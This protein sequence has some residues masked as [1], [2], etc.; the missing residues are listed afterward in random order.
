MP[1]RNE[2]G[3]RT[4]IFA[5][6]EYP[7]PQSVRQLRERGHQFAATGADYLV[8]LS[9]EDLSFPKSLNGRFHGLLIDAGS[10]R[11]V[12]WFNLV[13]GVVLLVAST[14]VL[15]ESADPDAHRV[16]IS[17]VV[18]GA[19]ALAAFTFAIIN[20]ETSGFAAPGVI[21]LLGLA[22]VAGAVFLWRESRAAHPVGGCQDDRGARGENGAGCR[23]RQ[24]YFGL[25][26]ATTPH[27]FLLAPV[28]VWSTEDC[29]PG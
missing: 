6:E 12:F 22:V 18:L 24:A 14:R 21:A 5:G 20:A 8:H 17:G 3:D 28:V 25:R 13:L 7:D 1:L 19:A 4:L 26:P 16:D 10:W 27:W 9:E 15:P 23:Q 2:R 29:P 11:T